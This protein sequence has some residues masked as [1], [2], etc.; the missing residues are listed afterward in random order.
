MFSQLRLLFAFDLNSKLSL[1]REFL[2]W[3][4]PFAQLV[5]SYEVMSSFDLRE[6]LMNVNTFAE[7]VW[8]LEK[9]Q[10]VHLVWKSES[11][12]SFVHCKLFCRIGVMF[13][14]GVKFVF[15]VKGK[16]T[17]CV[18]ESRRDF[19]VHLSFWAAKFLPSLMGFRYIFYSFHVCCS[20]VIWTASCPWH[21]NFSG[22]WHT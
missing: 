4:I 20:L 12:W 18:Y 3:W 21:E 2:W 10:F 5:W 9:Q 11:V 19:A 15:C 16:S 6:S 13:A 8:R 7:S 1:A 17:A 22:E 14:N